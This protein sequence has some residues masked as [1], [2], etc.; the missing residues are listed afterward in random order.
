MNCMTV[1]H[2]VHKMLSPSA[3]V[4][5][6]NVQTLSSLPSSS[7][8]FYSSFP[9]S[10]V[11]CFSHFVTFSFIVLSLLYFN[12]VFNVNFSMFAQERG[13]LRIFVSEA[14]SFRVS[15]CTQKSQPHT[16]T[17]SS[18][19]FRIYIF[20]GRTLLLVFFRIFAPPYHA[21]NRVHIECRSVRTYAFQWNNV[22]HCI[23]RE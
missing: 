13:T 16:H 18:L 10:A 4:D 7:F 3:I 11:A 5:E 17:R 22:V 8:H 20:E 15:G 9:L 12:F 14:D 1:R 6:M 23:F 21:M 2:C 19:A